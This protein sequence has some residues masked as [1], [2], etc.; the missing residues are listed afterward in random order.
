MIDKLCGDCINFFPEKTTESENEGL[1]YLKGLQ[2][3]A[4]E[5]IG[6]ESENITRNIY[7]ARLRRINKVGILNGY[8][9]CEKSSVSLKC[10]SAS[11]CSNPIFYLNSEEVGL[12]TF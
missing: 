7:Q 9:K 4:M 2:E 1:D 6:T 3:L 10:S 5:C 8:R 11:V 12:N